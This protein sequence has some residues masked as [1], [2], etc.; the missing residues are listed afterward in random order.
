MKLISLFALSALIFASAFAGGP[1]PIAM[2]A[3]LRKAAMAVTSSI[4]YDNLAKAIAAFERTLITHDRFDDFLQGDDKAL[5][6][7]EQAGLSLFLK[8]GCTT[9][10]NG[11]VLRADSL[12]NAVTEMGHLQLGRNFT[13]DEVKSLV[14]FLQSLSAKPRAKSPTA[15]K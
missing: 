9:C 12:S 10:H 4:P 6:S 13:P 15:S 5:S 8:A 1:A 11:P 14:A 7:D 3:D 2:T